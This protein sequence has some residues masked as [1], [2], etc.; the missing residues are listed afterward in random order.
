MNFL[1]KV[2]F[3]A[4]VG[5]LAGALFLFF[6]PQRTATEGRNAQRKADLMVLKEAFQKYAQDHLSSSE[7]LSFP[8]HPS[9]IGS[10][11][12]DAQPQYFNPCTSLVPRYLA[13]IPTD[14]TF[15][16]AHFLSCDDYFTGYFVYKD[17]FG[18]LMLAAP[19]AELGQK[20]E[21]KW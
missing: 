17:Q 11:L 8:S 1:Y 12:T 14:P 6:I 20:I 15:S 9:F 10:R 3:S 18:Q 19:G 5:I 13:L 4:L 16:Q 21:V 2:A 7:M